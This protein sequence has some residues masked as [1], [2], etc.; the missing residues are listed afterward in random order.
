MQRRAGP[1]RRF[2]AGAGSGGPAVPRM[3]FDSSMAPER[4]T[5][6]R[7][8][9]A[10][11]LAAA[12]VVV[13][14]VLLA[15]VGGGDDD[16]QVGRE[17]AAPR[18]PASVHQVPLPHLAAVRN[19]TP[20][21]DWRPYSGPVPILRYHVVGVAPPA[22][23]D[24]ELFV[25]PADFRA[26]MGWLDAHGYEAVG[27]ET[28][29]EAW[30]A[31]G[32]LPAKPIVLSFDG[33]RGKLLDVVAPE[34]RHRGWPGDLVLETEAGTLPTAAVARLLALGWDLEP[35]GRDPGAARHAVR[36]LFPTAAENFAFRQGRSVGSETAALEAAGYVG[37]TAS[38]G[39]FAES[40]E[41]FDMPRIT[42]FNASRIG[43]FAEAIHSRGEGVGA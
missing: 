29:E 1:A 25:T 39:G 10:A 22:T 4:R 36:A 18:R 19:A 27:L 14:V 24:T 32:R 42:I 43:G 13:V 15:V 26:Q 20:Q 33:V 12:G 21:P 9:A 16:S 8:L 30:F 31:G 5:V 6:P 35:S 37:A 28:V 11:A 38:G 17:M 7:L 40:S 23:S 3:R 41:P 2:G 34:L